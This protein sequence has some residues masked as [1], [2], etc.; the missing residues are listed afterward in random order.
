MTWA[1]AARVA[2][3]PRLASWRPCTDNLVRSVWQRKLSGQGSNQAGA[4]QTAVVRERE[5]ITEEKP[6]SLWT[7]GK[8]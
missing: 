6:V 2:F 3:Q 1:G 8:A 4:G 5:I 7:T